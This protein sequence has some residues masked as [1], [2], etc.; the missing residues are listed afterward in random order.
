MSDPFRTSKTGRKPYRNRIVFN[1]LYDRAAETGTNR[2]QISTV[3][4][5]RDLGIDRRSI[6]LAIRWLEDHGF[7]KT[8]AGEDQFG[9]RQ[10]NIYEIHDPLGDAD[11]RDPTITFN[12]L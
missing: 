1:Y 3:S 11:M 10:P 12:P 6:V 7:I 8:Y 2:I 5:M 4:I 9:T